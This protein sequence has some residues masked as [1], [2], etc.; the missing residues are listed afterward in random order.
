MKI[1]SKILGVI[2]ALVVSYYFAY[3]L[4]SHI[5]LYGNNYNPLNVPIYSI[6]FD[7]NIFAFIG[8]AFMISGSFL[9]KKY[10]P[11]IIRK[12]FAI[13]IDGL[14]LISFLFLCQKIFVVSP[15]KNSIYGFDLF[16]PTKVIKVRI[17]SIV[18]Y[19]FIFY[20][21]GEMN[22]GTIGKQSMK[23]FS[24]QEN[25]DKISFIISIQKTILYCMPFLAMLF[26]SYKFGDIYIIEYD[27]MILIRIFCFLFYSINLSAIFLTEDSKTITE[28]LTKTGV[29]DNSPTSDLEKSD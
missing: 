1:V 28:I 29:Y 21:I 17:Y 20:L 24:A 5:E 27:S 6:I 19:F 18:V 10:N 16:Y 11:L 25:G 23:L 14:I 13:L 22:Y 7:V 2:G 15:D 26:A 3:I 8:F 9:F 4:I 12:L